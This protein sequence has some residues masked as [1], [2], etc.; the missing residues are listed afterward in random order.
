MG[1]LYRRP[2][3]PAPTVGAKIRGYGVR[4]RAHTM[5]Y[6]GRGDPPG[7]RPTVEVRAPA[8]TGWVSPAPTCRS[9]TSTSAS[10][11]QH[12]VLG[13]ASTSR[14]RALAV[15]WREDADERVGDQVNRRVAAALTAPSGSRP[16]RCDLRRYPEG[17][18]S[19]MPP[20][21]G[22]RRRAAGAVASAD[23]RSACSHDWCSDRTGTQ[24]YPR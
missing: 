24:W 6:T 22:R 13:E 2:H 14:H 12:R 4:V 18:R 10:P 1:P 3:A 5:A 21:T 20:H 17:T 19:R 16:A 7:W 9:R 11:R 15:G 23:R 8:A